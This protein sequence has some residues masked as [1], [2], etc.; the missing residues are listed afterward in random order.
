VAVAAPLRL[1]L[2]LEVAGTSNAWPATRRWPAAR[3]TGELVGGTAAGRR[4]RGRAPRRC[5]RGPAAV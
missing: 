1:W 5:H 3:H 4:R 2:T